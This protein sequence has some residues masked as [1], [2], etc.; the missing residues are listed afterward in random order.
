MAYSKPDLRAI[1]DALER[2]G[3]KPRKHGSGYQARCP[4]HDDVNPSLSVTEGRSA[5]L[6]KCFAG[7]EYKD[8]MAAL[9]F[10]RPAG[11]KRQFQ[12]IEGGRAKKKDYPP[13]KLPAL[14]GEDKEG[15]SVVAIHYYPDG[16]GNPY[17]AVVRR[18]KAVDGKRIK[19]FSQRTH[20]EGALWAYAVPK[21]RP[22]YRLPELLASRDTVAIVEGEKCADA[23]SR[24][25]PDI[26]VTTWPG[27]GSGWKY[28]DWE[29]VRGR[30]V[31]LLSDADESGRKSMRGIA[32]RLAGMGCRI[33][34]G[35]VAGESG[36][37]VYDWIDREG[38]AV[39]A[40]LIVDHLTDYDPETIQAEAAAE[41]RAKA[42]EETQI[43]GETLVA[44]DHFRVLGLIDDLVAI[45][46][47]VG[48]VLKR[49]RE[50][51]CSP[52]TLVGM[53]PMTF[54]AQV[55]PGMSTLTRGI[56]LAIGDHLI[57]R[58]RPTRSGRHGGHDRPRGF[59]DRR[60]PDSLALGRPGAAGREGGRP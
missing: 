22:L 14:G 20:Y 46:L 28:T 10:D 43:A 60:R 34:I 49:S 1:L 2:C 47:S 53:A 7:C 35:L 40:Q 23:V 27:G 5:I 13:A 52:T 36:D 55:S 59:E 48:R 29:P 15:Y 57:R 9:G 19:K 4:A 31:T 11:D 44:N 25:W 18:E 41:E 30:D 6:L 38:A 21:K 26:T 12:T 17:V 24:A 37:D 56:A 3:S 58:G 39:A 50:A 54:W 32:A 51:M 8:I 33:K 42:S 16:K 45:R